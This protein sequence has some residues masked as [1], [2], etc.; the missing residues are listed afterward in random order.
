MM[1]LVDN[2]T[3]GQRTASSDSVHTVRYN[4]SLRDCRLL[5]IEFW[6]NQYSSTQMKE[7][8][9][10]M[11]SMVL[12]SLAKDFLGRKWLTNRSNSKCCWHYSWRC[13][14]QKEQNQKK[15]LKLTNQTKPLKLRNQKKPHSKIKTLFQTKQTCS[16]SFSLPCINPQDLV[17]TVTWSEW[18]SSQTWVWTSQVLSPVIAYEAT[19]ILQLALM[20]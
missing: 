11:A 6:T 17:H 2:K 12:D 13:W 1:S 7:I 18:K 5:A 14:Y 15:P 16:T 9:P 4:S 3:A 8:H 19:N 20:E 10:D